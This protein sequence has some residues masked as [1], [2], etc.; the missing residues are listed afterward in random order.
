MSNRRSPMQ[1]TLAVALFLSFAVALNGCE[2]FKSADNLYRDAEARY[3]K[4]EQK[5]VIIQLKAAL[6]KD[7]QHGPA[8]LLSAKAYNDVSDFIAAETEARKALELGVQA[9][10]AG[11]EL[12]RS[13]AGQGQFQKA[14]DQAKLSPGLSGE[15]LAKV[16][17]V[18]GDAQL[19]LRQ[20]EPAK[21]S[22]AS[23]V[24]AAPDY[25]GGYLG[26]ARLAAA[27]NDAAEA[28]RQID[29]VLQKA[30]QS[31]EGLMLKGDLF[32]AQGKIDEAIAAYQAAIK[33]NPNRSAPHFRL[34]NMYLAQ[35]KPDDVIKEV[36]A[37]QK[38]E[39]SNLEGSYLLAR[40]DFQQKK[41]SEARTHIQAVLRGAPDHLPS[42]LLAGAISA[43][44]GETESAEKNL[45]RVINAIPSSG[46]ARSLLAGTYLTKGQADLALETLTPAL[47]VA[48]PD[49]RIFALTG[50]AYLAKGDVAHATEM[51]DKAR[52]ANPQSAEIRTRLGAARLAQGDSERA[53]T[54]LEAAS[55]MDVKE[56]N[57][58]MVLILNYLQHKEFDKALAAIAVL[59]KKQPDSPIPMN[60]RGGI[61]LSKGDLKAARANFEQAM[62]KKADYLPA[63][64]NLAQLDIR[65]KNFAAAR[66]RYESV[67]AKDKQSVGALLGL[68]Q[69]A[70][71]EKNEKEY[72][73]WLNK[74][75]AAKPGAIEPRALLASFYLKQKQPQDALRI[76]NEAIAENPNDARALELLARVQFAAGD[77]DSGL[78]SYQK[79]VQQNPQ[80][81]PAYF[82][83]GLAEAAVEHMD[84]AEPALRKALQLQPSHVEAAAALIALEMRQKQ[85]EEALKIA[86]EFQ[87]ANPKLIAG[88]VLEANVLAQQLKYDP[89]IQLLNKA[90]SLQAQ[91]EVAT[92]IHQLQL[93]AKRPAEADTGLKQWLGAHPN[94]LAVRAYFAESY[95][96]RKQNKAAIEQYEIVLKAYPD[97]VLILN[98]LAAVYQ[99]EKDARAL[100]TAERAYK[101]RPDLPQI[102]DTLGWILVDQGQMTRAV[103]LLRKAAERAPKSMEIGYHYAVAL[104]KTGDKAGA[105]KQLEAILSSGQAF[106]QQEQA[107]ALL[108][109]LGS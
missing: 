52:I 31:L 37:A 10:Q 77:K 29:L 20:I 44:L 78:L 86:R 61:N 25:Y 69:L 50:Q 38:A 73:D 39:P 47:Q 48:K 21:D 67:L 36:Q 76:A 24:K 96:A 70:A 1:R 32:G 34:A 28:A 95:L 33:A 59:E 42:I 87:R 99:L 45:K 103:E 4:G 74:A 16:L 85:P 82:G 13:L 91:S 71:L 68:A 88:F 80:S 92:R 66:K 97:N 104:S 90:Q 65:D 101:L 55:A 11:L 53:I 102:A 58:D 93:A 3:Q 94:D 60:L 40:N 56:S 19:G 98:N 57:A 23:A 12:A 84:K 43:A 105:R 106:P 75:V 41:Y 83:L 17:M 72:G 46:Y 64:Q 54:D 2:R 26:L 109:Q 89:A 108:K 63:A 15:A 7:P 6:Q 18:R 107:K 5:A 79:L 81:A 49:E 27:K 62:A 35:N 51:F 100:P 22:Y 30:P 9:D 14:L 8:R